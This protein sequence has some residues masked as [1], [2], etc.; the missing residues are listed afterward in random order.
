MTITNVRS[1]H[2]IPSI[3]SLTMSIIRKCYDYKIYTSLL[4]PKSKP[5]SVPRD[6]AIPVMT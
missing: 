5:G 4:Y 3:R 1:L 2:W 6:C